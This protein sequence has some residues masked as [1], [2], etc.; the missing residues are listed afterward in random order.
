MQ[1]RFY[2]AT[3]SAEIADLPSA[4]GGSAKPTVPHY[5]THRLKAWE[6]FTIDDSTGGD[7]VDDDY[8]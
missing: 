4:L 6:G 7:D 8:Y 5:V 3:V 2:R 1:L